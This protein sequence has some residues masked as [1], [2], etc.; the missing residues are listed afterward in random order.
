MLW[1]NAIKKYFFGRS[2]RQDTSVAKHTGAVKSY[3]NSRYIGIWFDG[4]DRDNVAMVDAYARK[5][6]NSGKKVELFGYIDK[7]K[8]D[9]VIK[10]DYLEPKEVNWA[11]VPVANAIDVWS[12]KNYDLLLCM[13]THTCRPLEYLAALSKA[14]CR[15]GRYETDTVECYDIMVSLGDEKSLAQMIK[16]VDQLLTD[17]NKNQQ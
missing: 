1:L 3:A 4:S 9:E 15:V 12:G 14:I 11:G 5:L 10:F 8:K 6:T 7:V 13:H 17:I 2:L 16:Q